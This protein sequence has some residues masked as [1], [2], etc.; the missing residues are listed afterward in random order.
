MRAAGRRVRRVQ[1]VAVLGGEQKDQPIDEAEE[2]AEEVR[3]RQLAGAQL[4]A[5]RAIL[6]MRQEAVAEAEQRRLDAVAQLVAGGDA[7]LLARLAPALERAVGWRRAGSAEAAGMDQ[8][9]Q[10]GEVGEVLAL[11][12][13]AQVGFDIG[14]AREAGIVA[15]EAQ[16]HAVRST[17]PRARRRR[18]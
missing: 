10:R 15:H 2:L 13:A 17:G 6:G 16:A 11:E 4:L 14:R 18:H 5:Q 8:Q 12:D 1:Q 7:L 9:P 3:Q